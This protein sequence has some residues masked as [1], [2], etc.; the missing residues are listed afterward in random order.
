MVLRQLEKS[1]LNSLHHG[2]VKSYTSSLTALS[3]TPAKEP[4]RV[5][6]DQTRFV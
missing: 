2:S 5:R 3:A 1:A 6:N 4:G